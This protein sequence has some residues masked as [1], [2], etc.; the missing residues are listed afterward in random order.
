MKGGILI[1]VLLVALA[2]GGS[3]FASGGDKPKPGGGDKPKPPGGG[4]KPK[5]P[6]GGKK[7]PAKPPGAQNI[8]D[9]DWIAMIPDWFDQNGNSFWVDP[10]CRFVLEGDAFE[11]M[12]KGQPVSAVAEPTLA[13]TLAAPGSG[14]PKYNSVYGFI[15]YLID[16]E[17]FDTPE[18]ITLRVLQEGNALC[19]DIPPAQRSQG[20]AFW[21]NSFRDRITPYVYDTLGGINFGG[22]NS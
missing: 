22:N 2:F 6:S 9:D 7:K 15:D 5:P 10:E 3:A 21:F 4:D 8:D 19:A 20:L 13:E 1:L 11:T 16:Y 12:S 14:G 18:E 17:G